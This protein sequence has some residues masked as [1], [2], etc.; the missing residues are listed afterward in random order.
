MAVETKAQALDLV[1]RIFLSVEPAPIAEVRG[2]L[3]TQ[4]D[5]GGTPNIKK[6]DSGSGAVAA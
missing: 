4:V 2:A 3:S 5:N 6:A 1:A